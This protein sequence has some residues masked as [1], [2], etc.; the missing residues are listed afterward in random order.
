MPPE[1]INR[2]IRVEITDAFVFHCFRLVLTT[3]SGHDIEIMLHAR[4]LVDLI[5]QSSIALCEWQAQTS[6]DLLRKL[7]HPELIASSE[8]D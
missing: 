2:N 5:H 4:S 3:H 1:G 6:A 7:G 8:K